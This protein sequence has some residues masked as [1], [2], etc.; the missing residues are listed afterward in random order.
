M[1]RP[2][3]TR[4]LPQGNAIS[5]RH[6]TNHHLSL[7]ARRGPETLLAPRLCV[8]PSHA[9][10][11]R[12]EKRLYL[13]RRLPV[14]WRLAVCTVRASRL[15][16]SLGDLSPLRT[17]ALAGVAQDPSPEHQKMTCAILVLWVSLS[18][19]KLVW[20]WKGAPECV[21]ADLFTR[22]NAFRP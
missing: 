10:V 1:W 15:H 14:S 12:T 2:V 6:R 4:R 3:R 17:I 19:L 11:W 16:S 18:H 8:F 5:P 7:L 21:Y 20:V 9:P 13:S 22:E